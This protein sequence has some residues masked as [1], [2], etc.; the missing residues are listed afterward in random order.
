[1]L[2]EL[3]DFLVGGGEL[4]LEVGDVLPP[5]VVELVLE[6][7]VVVLAVLELLRLEAEQLGGVHQF[8]SQLLDLLLGVDLGRREVLEL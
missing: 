2:L 7:L 6:L 5:R 3:V 1:M 8:L 4:V